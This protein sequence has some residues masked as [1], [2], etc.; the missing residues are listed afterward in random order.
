MR[1]LRQV[2]K[3]LTLYDTRCVVLIRCRASVDPKS[4][5]FSRFGTCSN[6][7]IWDEKKKIETLNSVN[8]QKRRLLHV[9]KT[10]RFFLKW[11][12]L[13]ASSPPPQ[14]LPSGAWGEGETKMAPYDNVALVQLTSNE[15]TDS[16]RTE[17]SLSVQ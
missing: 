1:Q 15:S 8:R 4:N 3:S 5:L 11:Q 2:R 17:L 9:C 10:D 7:D 6:I 16:V 12:L 13:T 14:I